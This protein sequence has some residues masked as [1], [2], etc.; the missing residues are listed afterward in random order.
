MQ[1]LSMW[2]GIASLLGSDWLAATHLLWARSSWRAQS[3]GRQAPHSLSIASL[4]PLIQMRH[5]P[6]FCHGPGSWTKHKGGVFKPRNSP[7]RLHRLRFLE[8][9]CGWFGENHTGVAGGLV[10]VAQ[11]PYSF[12]SMWSHHRI[13]HTAPFTHITSNRVKMCFFSLALCWEATEPF[14]WS[15]PKN[16]LAWGRQQAW[17]KSSPNSWNL[18]K[19]N[20][21]WNTF[22]SWKSV[23]DLWY[24][25]FPAPPMWTQAKCAAH[26][27]CAS[28]L[29]SVSSELQVLCVKM[30]TLLYIA[31][32]A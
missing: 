4:C 12:S 26:T 13:P 14:C 23:G 30:Y 24:P 3:L 11:M 1:R 32:P 17:K 2:V 6:S 29:G 21:N 18:A 19:L 5:L 16:H 15:F 10:L 25:E 22:F 20:A 9:L 8:S 27:L 28:P 7:L 31:R